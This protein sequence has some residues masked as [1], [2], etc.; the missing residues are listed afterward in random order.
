M[1]EHVYLLVSEPRVSSLAVA[2]QV[3]KQAGGPDL[4]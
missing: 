4:K 1:P 3:L 2:L